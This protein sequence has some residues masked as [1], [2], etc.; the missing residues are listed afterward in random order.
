MELCNSQRIKRNAT[1]L[2]LKIERRYADGMHAIILHEWISSTACPRFL[3][4]WTMLSFAKCNPFFPLGEP[5]SSCDWRACKWV[6]AR[7]HECENFAGIRW[8]NNS[9]NV[10]VIMFCEQ[11]RT[12]GKQRFIWHSYGTVNLFDDIHEMLV[13]NYRLRNVRRN[14]IIRLIRLMMFMQ[15]HVLWM[16]LTIWNF[17]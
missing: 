17:N 15:F 12:I 8:C 13:G 3:P 11:T 5:Y 14:D 6:T 9:K 7:R 2:A 1:S 16:Q 4:L 10:P